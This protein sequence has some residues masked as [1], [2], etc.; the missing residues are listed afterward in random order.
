MAIRAQGSGTVES[1]RL[2]A[3]VV[4]DAVGYS[5]LMEADESGTHDRWRLM[6]RDL[7]LPTVS[8][9]GGRIIKSTGDGF[10][11]EFGSAV[12]AVRWALELQREFSESSCGE[13]IPLRIAIH[14]GDII[15][16][17]DDIFG[18]DVNIANR[19]QEFARPG[20]TIISSAVHDRVH[21]A[22]Q[23]IAE[24]LGSI[25]LK[26][27]NRPIQAFS[28][29]SAGH[30][31]SAR[32]LP[33]DPLRREPSIAVLPLRV[34]GSMPIDPYFSEGIVH[35][36]AESLAALKELFVVSSNTTAALAAT[37]TDSPSLT[38]LLQ[39]RYLVTGTVARAG[40]RLR[41]QIELSDTETRNIVW[42]EHY[43]VESE[44]LFATQDVISSKIARSLV[45][46]L[47]VS[48]LQR[49]MRKHPEDM[50][51]YELVLQ[52]RHKMFRFEEKDFHA[53]RDLL[54]KAIERDPRYWAAYSWLACWEIFKIGQGYSTDH[55]VE[56]REAQC[57]ALKALEY[58]AAD[59]IALAVY[60]HTQAFLF[61]E[62]DIALEL[63]DR[64]IFYSPNSAVAWGLS[65]PAYY[66]SGDPANAIKR[67]EY[68][69]VLSPLD[70]FAFFFQTSLTI[71]HYLT[72]NYDEAVRWGRK[73]LAMNPRYSANMR[74]LIASLAASGHPAEALKVA[75]AMVAIEPHFGVESFINRYPLKS[76]EVRAQYA[77]HLREGGLPG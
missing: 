61:G 50:A 28:I 13:M 22:L 56:S 19:L 24:D 7:I 1:R 32:Q 4:I 29:R 33:L 55:D 6:C 43:D 62:Y 47:R 3:I 41:L 21:S 57:F 34:L 39:T 60:G 18:S 42:K 31:D 26:N 63:F 40:E 76:P 70:P 68:A 71:S 67:S 25:K 72:S 27:I 53:A 59:P 12:A 74:P 14:I 45:P 10:L 11:I 66:Y 2:A 77:Q 5:R 58:N 69:L 44:E 30:A 51:A 8:K 37:T 16:E 46:H 17:P 65:G 75:Q 35:D 64:A 49:A 23:Y 20:H 36:V 54:Q 15:S 38:H 52:A 9:N 73:T 48:E